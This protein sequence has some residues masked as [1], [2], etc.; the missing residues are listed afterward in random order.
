M[1]ENIPFINTHKYDRFFCALVTPY[2]PGSLEIDEDMFREHVRR[3]TR[4]SDFIKTRGAIIVNPEA[5]EPHYL[6]QQE[7]NTLTKIVL[8]ERPRD[9]PIFSGFFG[10]TVS[11]HV[12]S[13][14]DTKSQG[15]DGLFVFPPS[16]TA[17]VTTAIDTAKYPEVWTEHVRRVAMATKL[18]LILHAVGGKTAEWGRGLA[19]ET[20]KM[21]ME[22]IPSIVGYK[23]IFGPIE[24]HLRAAWY[25]RSVPRHVAILNIYCPFEHEM[26][27]LGLV[28]GAV[29][30]AYNF[31][32][33]PLVNDCLAWE[34]G[35]MDKVKKIYGE[36]VI[37]IDGFVYSEHSR[38][39]IRYKLATWIR[40]FIPHPFM[41]PPLPPPR[42]GEAETM[43]KLIDKAGLSHISHSEFE[44][45]LA[46]KNKVL[47][48]FD[49]TLPMEITV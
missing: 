19:I 47:E 40:G 29:N 27:I 1:T 20:V 10:V 39:H 34:A 38:L 8:Q 6:T 12:K 23:M 15:V 26:R 25:L 46:T 30:G 21:M 44:R 45:T 36:Q 17:E 48:S 49:K 42:P 37:P 3:F 14:L 28:D 2:K 41:R 18:P 13:A 7:R 32:K 31:L 11:D 35:D 24:A 22:E 33:E 16:G 4:D 5:G 9:M 43:F